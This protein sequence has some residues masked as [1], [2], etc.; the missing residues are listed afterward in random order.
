[1]AGS[2]PESAW[3]FET[4]RIFIELCP[5]RAD[6]LPGSPKSRSFQLLPSVDWADGALRKL[7]F[8]AGLAR[9]DTP[10]ACCKACASFVSTVDDCVFRRNER[11]G[12]DCGCGAAGCEACFGPNIFRNRALSSS[13]VLGDFWSED[14]G[15]FWAASRELCRFLRWACRVQKMQTLCAEDT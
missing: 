15:A 6:C 5:L 3:A 8:S 1:M 14:A 4:S 10:K 12:C 2:K 11:R 13:S 7:G 9:G